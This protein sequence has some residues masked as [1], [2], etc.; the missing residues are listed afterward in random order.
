MYAR[1][2][3][4]RLCHGVSFS[5]S[6]CESLRSRCTLPTTE[7]DTFGWADVHGVSQPGVRFWASV[8]DAAMVGGMSMRNRLRLLIR[9]GA[10]L[11]RSS[12]SGSASPCNVDG[13]CSSSWSSE[14]RSTDTESQGMD[15]DRTP[16][17]GRLGERCR[18]GD[19]GMEPESVG[20]CRVNAHHRDGPGSSGAPDWEDDWRDVA[21]DGREVVVR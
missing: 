4:R 1:S 2:L 15:L 10:P 8:N 14:R 21:S 6:W 11:S 12:A 13:V 16:S 5:S 20:R 7:P 19:R 3:F 9:G 18:L 17:R